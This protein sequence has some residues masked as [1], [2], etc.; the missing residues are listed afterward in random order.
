MKVILP[1]PTGYRLSLSS[2]VQAAQA[3]AIEAH[4]RGYAFFNVIKL[5]HVPVN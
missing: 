1:L 5:D 3:L 4:I 2:P